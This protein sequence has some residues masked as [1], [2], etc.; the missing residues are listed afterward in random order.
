MPS[1]AAFPEFHGEETELRWALKQL[2]TSRLIDGHVWTVGSLALVIQVYP[3]PMDWREED[4]PPGFPMHVASV[5]PVR[6]RHLR[7]PSLLTKVESILRESDIVLLLREQDGK[8]CIVNQ[9]QGRRI[10]EQNGRMQDSTAIHVSCDHIWERAEV[11]NLPESDRQ[12]IK[13]SSAR[14]LPPL[15]LLEGTSNCFPRPGPVT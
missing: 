6:A 10:F 1:G 15:S 3:S 2:K 8:N 4:H 11:P 13:Q 14:H 12:M 7:D 5:G 9:L